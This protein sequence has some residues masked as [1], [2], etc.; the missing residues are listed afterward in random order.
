[1]GTIRLKTAIPGPRTRE[2]LERR[3]RYVPQGVSFATPLFVRRAEGAV[4]E[5]VDGNVFIDFAGGIAV[6]NAGHCPPPVVEAVREQAGKFLHTCFMV[7]G[8]ESYVDL[9]EALAQAAPGP[10][11]K[12]VMFVNSG[13]EAVENGVKIA[14]KATGRQAV[15]CFDHAFHGRTLLTMTL[16]GHLMPYKDGFGPFAPEV[17]RFP[18]AYCYRC[19][20]GKT[21]PGCGLYCL[22]AFEEGMEEKVGGRNVAALVV[23]PVQGE[24][25]FVV[26]PPGYLR[27]LKEICEKYGILFVADEV[28]TGFGRTGKLF[29]VEHDGIEPDI[30]LVAKSI[31]AG[32]PLAGVIGKAEVMDAVHKGG[33]GGTYGG[34]PLSCAAALEVLKTINDPAFLARGRPVGERLAR[35]CR[36]LQARQPLVGDVRALGGMVAME[37]VKDRE[38][39]EPAAA[40]TAAIIQYAYEHGLI[41]LKAGRYGNVLRFLPPLVITD[42]QLEE[43]L[44]VLADAFASVT[45]G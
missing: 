45:G 15:V 44:S 22:R 34:N 14:R 4:L 11:P 12:K 2:L 39:K 1:M 37:L 38:T 16:T 33:I 32:L 36:D 17:Y 5:D 28:Q 13:A 23:E 42:D 27:G 9:A 25:G 7:V 24:G 31:A 21:H 40:E 30:L 3:A 41:L 35:F 8:Y 18:Y 26:P 29:A 19:A 6:V 10:T 20:Y 43:A